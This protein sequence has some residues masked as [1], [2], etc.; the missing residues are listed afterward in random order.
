[1]DLASIYYLGTTILMF[2]VFVYIVART[3]RSKEKHKGEAP[4]FRMMD[5]DWADQ[6]ITKQSPAAQRVEKPVHHNSQEGFMSDD[7]NKEYDGITYREE[8]KSPLVF[9]ILF[10]GLLIWGVAFMGHY[11]FGGWSSQAEYAQKKSAKEAMLAAVQL[12]GIAPEAAAPIPAAK[13]LEYLAQGKKEYAERCAA[14]HGESAKGGIGPDLTIAK[15]KYGKTASAIKASITEGR[16]GGM[17][18][19]KND[20]SHEKV[21]GLA[22]YLLSL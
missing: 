15:Y 17:P 11:L 5:D 14:C 9:R 22:L 12:K 7:H 3:Y 19:F 18:A 21:E 10:T 8:K 20:L 2:A 16:P 6:P 4:K 1:M 13:K